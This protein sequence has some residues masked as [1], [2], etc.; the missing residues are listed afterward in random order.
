QSV[1]DFGSAVVKPVTDPWVKGQKTEAVARGLAEAGAVLL[2]LLKL[3]SAKTAADAKKA[4]ETIK[5]AEAAEKALDAAKVADAAK[6][7]DATKGA[8]AANAAADALKAD[9]AVA[10]AGLDGVHVNGSAPPAA[11]GRAGKISDPRQNEPDIPRRAGDIG[12]E[13]IQWGR[14]QTAED[15]AQTIARSNEMS[16]N[17]VQDMIAKGLRKDWV[18]K[19]MSLY[20]KALKSGGSKLKNVQLSPRLNLMQKIIE[21]WPK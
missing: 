11:Q 5:A 1:L 15:V 7:A 20:E 4:A 13:I 16:T 9:V 10:E 12:Q 2:G 14:G 8:Q 18:E 17:V 6:A 19:Q 21:S 3:G